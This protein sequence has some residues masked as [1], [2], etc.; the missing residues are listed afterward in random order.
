MK[1]LKRV[2]KFGFAE[3]Y[4]GVSEDG[5]TKVTCILDDSCVR[6]SVHK[7][8]KTIFKQVSRREYGNH[9]KERCYRSATKAYNRI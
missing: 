2:E 8:A 4:E 3:Y 7:K 9:E 1:E 5:Q 6:Y